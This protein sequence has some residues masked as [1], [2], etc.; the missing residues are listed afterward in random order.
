MTGYI[1]YLTDFKEHDA[2]YVAFGGGAKGGKITGKGTIRTVKLDFEDVYFVKELE[3]NLF[4]V[5]QMCDK[6]NSVIFTDTECFVMS[7]N[8]KLAD[9]SQVLLKVSRKNNMYSFYMKNI[10]PKKDLTYLLAKATNDESMLLHRR[11]GHINLK[12]INKLVKDNLVRGLPS[13]RFEN[14]QTC[15][16]CLKGKQHKVSFKSNLQNFISQP[17]FMLHMD[18]FGP[19]SGLVV[20]PYFKTPY[21]LFKGRS[22]ALSFMRPFGCHVTILNTLNQLGKF[23]GKSDEGIF[24]GYS[25]TSKA[26]R[27]YNIRTRKVKEN[28]HITF[29]ENK[30][31]ITGGGP[32]WLFDIDA[33]SKLINYAPVFAGINSNDF[34]DNSLFESFSQASDGHN[35]YK[36]GPSQASENDDQERHNADSSTKTVNN[37]RRVNTATPTYVDYPNDP[38]MTDLEDARIFDDA[39]DDRDEGAKADYNNLETMEP[40]KTLMDLPPRKRAIGTKWVCRNKRDQKG[41]VVRNKARLVAQGYRQEEG[42]DYDEVF[43]PVAR[44]E[45]IRL[46]LAYVSFMDFTIYQID[47]KSAFLY[48]TI[49]EEVYVSQPPGFVDLEFPDRVYKAEKALYGLHQAPRAWYE[50]LSTYLL[51]N[52][53]RRVTIDKTLFIK[54]IKDDILLVQVYVDDIIFGSTKSVKSASTPMETHKPLSQDAAGTDGD[55]HLYNSLIGSLIYLKGQPALGI[56]YP[57]D[58]P[59]EL[60]DYSNSDYASASLDRKS[61]TRGYQFLGLKLKG[62]LINDGYAD[63]VQHADKKELAIP[64][65]TETGKELSNPLMAGSLPKTTLPTLLVLNVVS[66]VQLL[67]YAASTLC[68]PSAMI[69]EELARMGY[70]KPSEKLTFYKAFFSPQWKFFI[71]TILQCLSAKTTSWNEFSSTMASSIICLANNQN[72]NFSKYIIHNLKKNLEVGV[73]FYMFPRKHKPMRKEKKERKETKVSPI[74]LPTEEHVPTPSSDPLPSDEDSMPLKELMVL[75]INLSNK[76]LDLENEVI[77]MK[78]SHKAKIAKLESMVGNLEGEN[79]SLTNELKSFNSKVKSPAVKDTVVDKEKSS[80]QERKIVDIDA[81]AEVNLENE[82]NLDLAHEETILSMHDAIDADGKE[83]T[84]EMVEVI[85]TA[86]IIVDEVSTACGELNAADEEPVSAAPTNI[87]TAQPSEAT[88]TTVDI[89]TTP[90]A[91]GIVFHDVEES[92][93]RTASSKAHVKDKVKAKLV[94]E[95]KVLKSRKAQIAI[96]EEFTRKIEAEWNADMQDNIDWNE[97]MAG[98]KMDFFKGMSYEEIRPLFEEEYNKVQT[99][100]KEVLEIDA[101]RI[102]ALR[103]RTRKENV[104]KDQTAKKQKGH[105]LEK[106]N[107]EKQKLEEQQEAKELKRNL[108]I[109]HDDE[110]DVFV[111]VTPLSSKP[112]II[113]DYKIYKE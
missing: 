45:A 63:L 110:D 17:L 46:F 111:N 68:L 9:E 57:K 33:F 10:V 32:E 29:L 97:N 113:M 11:L 34:T 62:Y 103:K 15:V 38:L 13:K 8:F 54:K 84:K 6:K 19:T 23:D 67:L 27:V 37:V 24:V 44:I 31:M 4:S 36:H 35:K 112:P 52:G 48:G 20:K 98:F 61:T 75:C 80:K 85:T 102:K 76:V 7:F 47:V 104:E 71:H 106:E 100:F 28:L 22:P 94:K 55:V 93:T 3:F 74:E 2:G 65:Q 73:P 53:F 5:L 99:L 88:K 42:I 77:E 50:T 18:L 66:A 89:T 69:F 1:S 91:K 101:E 64:G 78:Y 12:N 81:D 59:L 40:K 86:K 82:Y 14:D 49:K 25:T 90:K 21:E 79:R 16:A 87:T 30:P 43:A 72:F 95:P 108:E 105:E 92:T 58:S 41:I 96:D 39:Y 56:W 83:V 109:V 51:D 107:A 60:I 26:S 70:M